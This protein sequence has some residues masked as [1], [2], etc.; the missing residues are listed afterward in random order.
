[1]KVKLNANACSH[2][3]C[4]REDSRCVGCGTIICPECLKEPINCKCENKDNCCTS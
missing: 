3:A 1:M 4:N 2:W